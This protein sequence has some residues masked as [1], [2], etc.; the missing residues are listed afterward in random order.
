METKIAERCYRSIAKRS[1]HREAMLSKIAVR[2]KHRE[3]SRSNAP[4]VIEASRS[5]APGASQMMTRRWVK[6][7]APF[8]RHHR[9]IADASPG[10]FQLT[11]TRQQFSFIRL[12]GCNLMSSLMNI[13][14]LPRRCR[15]KVTRIGTH[16]LLHSR[17]AMP[18]RL[19]RDLI[20]VVSRTELT[21]RGSSK[22]RKLCRTSH[23][24]DALAN[25]ARLGTCA[26]NKTQKD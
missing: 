24:F 26:A 20:S 16:G 1:K 11:L 7:E 3:A 25:F 23:N 12:V 9:A 21:A 6:V 15:P 19:T 8:A 17:S 14:A 2:S 4:D 10:L 18:W 5:D 13:G 22:P